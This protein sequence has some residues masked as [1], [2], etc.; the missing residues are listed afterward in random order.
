[1]L[2]GLFLYQINQDE[3]PGYYNN[4]YKFSTQEYPLNKTNENIQPMPNQPM[5]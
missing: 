2:Y 5:I 3:F 1:M 4:W